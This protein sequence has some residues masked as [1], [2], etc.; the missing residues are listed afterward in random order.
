MGQKQMMF[1][2]VVNDSIMI[3]TFKN[4]KGSKPGSHTLTSIKANTVNNHTKASLLRIYLILLHKSL[5]DI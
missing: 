2:E 3:I 1:S 5:A 4:G